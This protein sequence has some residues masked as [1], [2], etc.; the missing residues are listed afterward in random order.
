MKRPRRSTG[1]PLAFASDGNQL[2]AEVVEKAEDSFQTLSPV[3]RH[4]F[5]QLI[6]RD[7]NLIDGQRRVSRRYI[8]ISFPTEP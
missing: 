7:H 5:Y 2:R 1:S 8:R 4:I 6:E 3:R